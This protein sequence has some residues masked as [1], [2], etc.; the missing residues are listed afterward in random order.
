[1][2]DPDQEG[3]GRADPQDDG[4]PSAPE[5][6]QAGRPVRD[7]QVLLLAG[8]VVALVLGTQALG[9]LVPGFEQLLALQPVMVLVLIVVTVLILAQALRASVRR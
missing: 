4:A 7:R 2:I 8:I 6:G 9:L 3:I 1:V 5:S